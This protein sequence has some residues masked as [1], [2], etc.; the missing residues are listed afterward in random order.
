MKF[1]APWTTYKSFASENKTFC[2]PKRARFFS[3]FQIAS[4]CMNAT[5]AGQSLQYRDVMRSV[6]KVHKFV[7]NGNSE[8]RRK[9]Q[10]HIKRHFVLSRLSARA[11]RLH[12]DIARSQ[13]VRQ[14]LDGVFSVKRRC[15]VHYRRVGNA[16]ASN[17]VDKT[18]KSGV[19]EKE[20]QVNRE[21]QAIFTLSKLYRYL[22]CHMA[23]R[24]AHAKRLCNDGAM[25]W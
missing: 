3:T 8:E 10:W 16:L 9:S 5:G 19:V 21:F 1:S 14:L 12:S 2:T 7:C 22:Q 11:N 25:N 23:C 13:G 6:W 20:L 17:G 4:D 18:Q 24:Y 15:E